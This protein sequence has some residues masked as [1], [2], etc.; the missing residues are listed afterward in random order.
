M[1]PRRPA[2]RAVACLVMVVM[3]LLG[4]VSHSLGQPASIVRIVPIGED[5]VG[6]AIRPGTNG[7]VALESSGDLLKW[8][9]VASVASVDA[10]R[11]FVDEVPWRVGTRYYRL[12]DPGSTAEAMAS[13]WAGHGISSYRF[14]LERVS[15]SRAPY[16]LTAT[17]TIHPGGK[18]ISGAMADGEPMNEP[19]PA[20]FPRIEDLFEV[21]SAAQKIGCRQVYAI[22]DPVLGYPRRCLID[23]R[24]AGVPPEENNALH[25][26]VLGIEVLR[27]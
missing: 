20:L 4:D 15:T 13:R 1:R 21:L 8:A 12:R 9:E 6:L 18:R 17:V 7:W 23:R 2:S 10:V 11:L 16:V 22:Y 5:L 26:R 25:Y 3:L 19:D 14:Q 24:Q 27:L